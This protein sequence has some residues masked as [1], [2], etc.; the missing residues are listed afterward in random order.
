MILR[1]SSPDILGVLISIIAKSN[2]S[3]TK[4]SSASS[5]D[6]AKET[7]KPLCSK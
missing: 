2:T 5:P 4:N 7:S 3:S 6:V 1:T